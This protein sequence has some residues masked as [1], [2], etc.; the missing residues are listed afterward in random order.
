MGSLIINIVSPT[1]ADAKWQSDAK[2]VFCTVGLDI[3]AI[4]DKVLQ[5]GL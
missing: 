1:E 5:A 4:V 2:W 3:A